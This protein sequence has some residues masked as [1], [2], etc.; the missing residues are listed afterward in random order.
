MRRRSLLFALA[1]AVCLAA[2]PLNTAPA[3]S[4]NVVNDSGS[5]GFVRLT[6]VDGVNFKIEFLQPKAQWL[7]SIN[8]SITDLPIQALFPSPITFQLVSGASSHEFML[9]SDS[10]NKRFDPDGDNTDLTYELTRGEAPHMLDSL[11]LDG[12]VLSAPQ[13]L[14]TLGTGASQKTYDFT[15]LVGGRI[16]FVM[17]APQFNGTNSFFGLF[18][19][20]GA[21]ASGSMAFSQI[22][23][24]PTSAALMGVGLIG[25]LFHRRRMAKRSLGA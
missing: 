17:T 13:P 16:Q 1:A 5:A 19:T 6:N 9:S 22:V 12:R 4:I 3:A 10:W 25:L 24:E 20:V 2:G 7:N 21:T 18:Q 15:P 14:L 11:V 8:G 23:P